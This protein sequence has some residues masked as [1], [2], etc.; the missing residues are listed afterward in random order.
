MRILVPLAVLMLAAA[1]AGAASVDRTDPQHLTPPPPGGYDLPLSPPV[2]RFPLPSQWLT[3]KGDVDWRK[4][5]VF[6]K[7]LSDA[8][9]TRNFTEKLPMRFRAAY[10][11]EILGVAFGH[12]LNLN[13][14]GKLADPKMIYLFRNGDSTQCGVLKMP[15]DDPR[16][17]SKPEATR[18]P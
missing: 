10:K 7:K 8:C 12:G 9:A 13:D 17:S 6:D 1:P 2:V 16:I 11:G 4:A 18:Q 15:N 14:P 3:I 5:G